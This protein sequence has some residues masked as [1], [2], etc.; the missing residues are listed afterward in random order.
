MTTIESDWEC[1]RLKEQLSAAVTRG[2]ELKQ[3][4]ESLRAGYEAR[5]AELRE[6][7]QR[8]IDAGFGNSTD[9][10]KQWRAHESSVSLLSRTDPREALNR[11]IAAELRRMA[12]DPIQTCGMEWGWSPAALRRRA[13]DL[14]PPT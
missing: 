7:L 11:A 10:R 5:I 1:T 13:D 3:E 6:A 14:D 12:D 2:A 4:N 9:F 8:Y